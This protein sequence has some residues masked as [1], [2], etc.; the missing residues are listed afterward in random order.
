M[1]NPDSVHAER[2]VAALEEFGFGGLGITG[3]DLTG[4]GRVLQLG[5]PPNRIDLLTSIDGVTFDEVWH[6]RIAGK[7]GDA[8]VWYI[9]RETLIRNKRAAGRPQ[10][11]ADL[12]WLDK[13]YKP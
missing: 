11:L 8:T 7:Y 13:N 10:D 2:L 4:P 5:T 1:V 3:D 6:G 12:S 9:D